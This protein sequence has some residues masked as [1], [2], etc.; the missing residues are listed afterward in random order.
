[1]LIDREIQCPS[2]KQTTV[3]A[4]A[5]PDRSGKAEKKFSFTFCRRCGEKLITVTE[6]DGTATVM[7]FSDLDA[8]GPGGS[9]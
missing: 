2:C 5:S 7:R 4:I 3:I 9:S 1:M 8:G 6:E